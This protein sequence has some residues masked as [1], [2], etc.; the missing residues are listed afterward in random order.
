MSNTFVPDD[1]GPRG[2]TDESSALLGG[3]LWLCLPVDEIIRRTAPTRPYADHLVEEANMRAWKDMNS[4]DV[5]IPITADTYLEKLVKQ[6]SP[7]IWKSQPF[8][9][10]I[11]RLLN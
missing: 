11:L 2:C 7:Y 5:I 6:N 4:I 10:E 8:P 3:L 1:Y 9:A